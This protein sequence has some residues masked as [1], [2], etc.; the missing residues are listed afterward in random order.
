MR[1]NKPVRQTEAERAAL[2][3]QLQANVAFENAVVGVL[4]G[5]GIGGAL[6]SGLMLTQ[7]LAS[8]LPI[9]RSIAAAIFLAVMLATLIFFIG[10]LVAVTIVAPLNRFLEKSKRRS[11]MPYLGVSL[12]VTAIALLAVTALPMFATPGPVTI[13]SVVLASLSAWFVF[14]RRMKPVWYAAKRQ[15]EAP[16]PNDVVP[17]RLH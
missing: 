2:I 16:P 9:I 3:A 8:G 6:G 4:T 1:P 10:F 14:A 15:E 5:A 7:S 11:S 13:A 12:V 17:F